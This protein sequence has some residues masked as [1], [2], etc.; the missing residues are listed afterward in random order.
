MSVSKPEENG[1]GY[2]VRS[3][4]GKTPTRFLQKNAPTCLLNNYLFLFAFVPPQSASVMFIEWAISA[5]FSAS[6]NAVMILT[7]FYPNCKSKILLFF[8]RV[9]VFR[10]PEPPETA[11]PKSPEK[12]GTAFSSRPAATHS[13]GVKIPGFSTENPGK[14]AFLTVG[15]KFG[16]RN[17]FALFGRP[18]SDANPSF[19]TKF[20]TAGL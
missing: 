3:E 20:Q 12:F 8:S 4:S 19:F 1:F 13:Q 9:L 14:N 2:A 7:D 18:D 16:F 17:F 6:T 10:V 15:A 11:I 5:I